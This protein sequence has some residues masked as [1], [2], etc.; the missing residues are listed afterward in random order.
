[1][2]G[3]FQTPQ[4]GP[5]RLV[6]GAVN[7]EIWTEDIVCTC[8]P[9]GRPD[10]GEMIVGCCV[11]KLWHHVR[12]Q[13]GPNG[14]YPQPSS[15]KAYQCHACK[16]AAGKNARARDVDLRS[17]RRGKSTK[18]PTSAAPSSAKSTSG[19]KFNLGLLHQAPAHSNEATPFPGSEDELD[20]DMEDTFM[21]VKAVKA[22][23]RSQRPPATIAK[24]P[25]A[26][27]SRNDSGTGGVTMDEETRQYLD[28]AVSKLEM[29]PMCQCVEQGIKAGTDTIVCRDCRCLHV[30][31]CMLEPEDDIVGHGVLCKSCRIER[32]GKEIALEQWKLEQAVR[33]FETPIF[34][35]LKTNFGT[36]V[37]QQSLPDPSPGHAHSPQR[38]PQE[39]H[40][41]PLLGELLQ[42][43]QHRQNL[44]LR[45]PD[46]DHR[47]SGWQTHSCPPCAAGLCGRMCREDLR[48]AR[49]PGRRSCG[50]VRWSGWGHVHLQR[51][52]W[53]AAHAE[54]DGGHGC[55]SASEVHAGE[56]DGCSDGAAWAGVEG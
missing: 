51:P 44:Q 15:S 19:K 45:R 48:P 21:E 42:A 46:D 29:R 27:L 28:E 6:T 5:G 2:A 30:A 52:G 56:G 1:M 49:S 22:A 53:A 12:C 16:S 50:A 26:T 4:S 33:H 3:T 36:E 11:C 32:A 20:E 14:K 17:G 37:R 9:D 25:L 41:P 54:T 38:Q 8:G 10:D 24:V 43:P 7:N 18:T 13:V 47:L 39:C 55:A 31:T 40:H 35:I 34:L 23:G